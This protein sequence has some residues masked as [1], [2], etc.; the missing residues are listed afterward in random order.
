MARD[1]LVAVTAAGCAGVEAGRGDPAVLDALAARLGWSGARRSVLAWAARH[2]AAA[3]PG[4][5]SAAE[6]HALGTAGP[7]APE[8]DAWGAASLPD[9][10]R[11]RLVWPGPDWE[12]VTGRSPGG[13]LATRFVDLTLR[14]AAAVA[15]AGLPARLV[16]GVLAAAVQDLISEARMAHADDFPALLA[17]VRRVPPERWADYLAALS[18]NG[19]L[20]PVEAGSGGGR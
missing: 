4:L 9:D 18:A 7:P 8:L 12:E 10:G 1:R 13:L 17:H 5:F 15:E 2:E 11:L 14:A 16:P 20:V 19:P 3:V 6:C